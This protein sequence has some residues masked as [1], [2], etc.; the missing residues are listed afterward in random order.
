MNKNGL[1]IYR[2]NL[3]LK[4]SGFVL[5]EVLVSVIILTIGL[6][7]VLGA[8]STSVNIL[9]TSEK[10]QTALHL[11]QQKLHQ[12]MTTPVDELRDWGRGDFGDK[13]PDFRWEYTI[14]EEQSEFYTTESGFILQAS[15]YKVITV[16]VSYP[17]RGKII[18]PV[19]LVTYQ[20]DR[21]KYLI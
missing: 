16:I 18:S 12:I 4:K 1:C 17:Y 11:A 10:Y 15:T 14:D 8:F 19:I 13:H 2:D 7:A 21:L 9:V 6:T 5:L 3:S 20:T